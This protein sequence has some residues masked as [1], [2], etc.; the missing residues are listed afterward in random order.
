MP[1]SN[2][3]AAKRAECAESKD[4]ATERAERA[5][6][7]FMRGCNCCQAVLLA[8]SA[9]LGMDEQTLMRLGSS[10]GAGMGRMREVC[11][12]VTGMLMALGLRRGYTLDEGDKKAHYEKV[13]ELAGRFRSQ[14]GSIICRELL[15]GVK[16]TE[17]GAPEER[18][19]E[20]YRKRPCKSYCASA[21][22]ILQKELTKNE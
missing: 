5:E 6:S 18:T 14:N 9:E 4:A 20:Y 11:G 12:A 10:F 16:V 7:N 15:E 19:A 21:A 13:R 1:E 2:D 17:G 22:A 8:F 3:A